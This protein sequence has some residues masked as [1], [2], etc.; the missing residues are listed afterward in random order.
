MGGRGNGRKWGW[1]PPFV[2]FTCMGRN[3]ESW[4]R[5]ECPNC[6]MYISMSPIGYG[7]GGQ[8]VRLRSLPRPYLLWTLARG[9]VDGRGWSV[10]VVE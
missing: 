2:I 5:G 1:N 10:S 6:S 3:G 4:S 8:G 9:G 7:F